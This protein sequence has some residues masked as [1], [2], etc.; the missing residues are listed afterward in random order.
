MQL[1][2]EEFL[3]QYGPGSPIEVANAWVQAVLESRDLRRVWPLA[4]PA[5]RERGARGWIEANRDH[6]GVAHRDLDELTA[7]LASESPDD[8]L[9][10]RFEEAQL[11]GFATVW[12]DVDLRTWGFA[13]GTR[14]L[15]VDRELVMLVDAGSE[16]AITLE[17]DTA[18]PAIGLAMEYQDDRWRVDDLGPPSRFV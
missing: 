12:S 14:P 10:S 2:P 16:E 8:P 5:L 11:A 17:E 3:A 9:W 6:P 18:L 7:A 15:G 4:T 1:T 13:S